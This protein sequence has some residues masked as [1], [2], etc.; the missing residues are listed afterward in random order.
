[1]DGCS[2]F[3]RLCTERQVSLEH[4]CLITGCSCP[5]FAA[6]IVQWVVYL[7]YRQHDFQLSMFHNWY[8]A[9]GGVFGLQAA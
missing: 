8:S 6:S 1:M 4:Q 7:G 9:V 5:C 3:D 2:S